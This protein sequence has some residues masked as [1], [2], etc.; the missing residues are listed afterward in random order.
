MSAPPPPVL[1]RYRKINYAVEGPSHRPVDFDEPVCRLRYMTPVLL[2]KEHSRI[3]SD[4]LKLIDDCESRW[5]TELGRTTPI[6]SERRLKLEQ[7]WM[8]HFEKLNLEVLETNGMS[9]AD[10]VFEAMCWSMWCEDPTISKEVNIQWLAQTHATLVVWSCQHTKESREF[11]P[12]EDQ[13]RALRRRIAGVVVH[14]LVQQDRFQVASKLEGDH[15]KFTTLSMALSKAYQARKNPDSL[16]ARKAASFAKRKA[17][18]IKELMAR[19]EDTSTVDAEL[20]DDVEIEEA[21]G[22]LWR[23]DATELIN[24]YVRLAS[25]VV[26]KIEFDNQWVKRWAVE[27]SYQQPRFKKAAVQGLYDWVRT[28]C[29]TEQPEEL[30]EMFR[31]VASE[32]FWPIGAETHKFRLRETRNDKETSQTLLQNEIGADLAQMLQEDSLVRPSV[33]ASDPHGLYWEA[34]LLVLIQFSLFQTT[35]VD[36]MKEY[37]ILHPHTHD[38]QRRMIRLDHH[39]Q[40]DKC[41]VLV[42][43]QRKWWVF[44]KQKLFPT[45]GFADAVLQK[46]HCIQ[47]RKKQQLDNGEDVS[48]LASALVPPNPLQGEA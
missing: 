46:F 18:A 27:A 35:K 5:A 41:P 25:R 40:I 8:L 19:G 2:A 22:M 20:S 47:K 33:T 45:S 21:K 14:F 38:S 13:Y 7:E 48:P 42:L 12:T 9:G 3:T 24:T 17:E 10:L 26:R 30:T 36:W 29:K 34:L 15:L 28:R 23:N 16:V 37:V 44:Y 4:A 11:W 43:A 31:D 32:S 1:A 39:N 6:G